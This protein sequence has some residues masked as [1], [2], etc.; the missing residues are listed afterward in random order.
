YLTTIGTINGNGDCSNRRKSPEGAFCSQSGIDPPAPNPGYYKTNEQK[1]LP[2][3][4]ASA[5]TGNLESQCEAGYT[6]VRCGE[7]SDGYY[8]LNGSCKQCKSDVPDW[9][10]PLVAI[11]GIACLSM[12]FALMKKGPT[13]G[14][15]NII[16]NFIQT[17]AVFEQLFASL[18]FSPLLKQTFEMLSGAHLNLELASPECVLSK[19]QLAPKFDLRYKLQF[20]LLLPLLIAAAVAPVAI[21]N[22]YPILWVYRKLRSLLLRSSGEIDSRALKAR[23]KDMFLLTL[24]TYNMI[25]NII[26]IVLVSQSLTIF[27]CTQEADGRYYLGKDNHMFK[28]DV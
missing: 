16:V 7:C 4:P 8:K 21:S 22:S 2:C 19:Y 13:R 9:F 26:Y 27:D 18:D 3:I 10:V 12:L 1:F 14:L 5:C 17:V 24:Q 28:S 20:T 11:F 25:L 15:V 23:Q 6:G